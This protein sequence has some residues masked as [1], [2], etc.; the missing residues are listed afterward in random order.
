MLLEGI[1]KLPGGA[2]RLVGGG[3]KLV[4]GGGGIRIGFRAPTF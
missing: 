4:G 3:G 2:G 1:P